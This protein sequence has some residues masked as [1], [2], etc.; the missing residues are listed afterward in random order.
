MLYAGYW[1]LDAGC[2]IRDVRY[3]ILDIEN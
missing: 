1:I 3:V 2:G